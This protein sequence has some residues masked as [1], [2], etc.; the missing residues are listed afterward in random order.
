M[1]LNQY[2]VAAARQRLAVERVRNLCLPV[3]PTQKQ[4]DMSRAHIE[5]RAGNSGTAITRA[6]MQIELPIE[7]RTRLIADLVTGKLDVR[8]LWRNCRRRPGSR[9]HPLVETIDDHL[10]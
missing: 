8:R 5:K 7:Y 6:H 4:A 9:A 2:Q 3:P 1:S 10:G